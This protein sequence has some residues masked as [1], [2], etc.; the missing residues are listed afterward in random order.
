MFAHFHLGLSIERL[1]KV[2][3]A[4][5]NYFVMLMTKEIP[6]KSAF[7]VR[8]KSESSSLEVEAKLDFEY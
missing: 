8:P 2:W 3:V 5:H 1:L 4:A 6:L 7:V